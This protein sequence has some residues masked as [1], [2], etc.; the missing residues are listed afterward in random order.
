MILNTSQS[1][2]CLTLASINGWNY[3]S[4][5]SSS[6]ILPSDAG[7]PSSAVSGQFGVELLDIRHH[8]VSKL[9]RDVLDELV[10]W[11]VTDGQCLGSRVHEDVGTGRSSVGSLNPA[12]TNTIEHGSML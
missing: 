6:V 3:L 10:K 5:Y 2:F 8:V 12:L 7:F 9:P 4:I 1:V 11:E